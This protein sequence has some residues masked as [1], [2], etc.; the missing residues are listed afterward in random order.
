MPKDKGNVSAGKYD[1][2]I[3]FQNP[4]GTDDGQGGQTGSW[5]DAY[6]CWAA[7][8]DFPFGRGAGRAFFAQQ[9]YPTMTTMIATRFQSTYHIDATKRIKYVKNGFAHIYK[10]LGAKDPK[11]AGIEIILF[12]QEDQAKGAN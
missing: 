9:L 3:T 4:P 1:R 7:I 12:C 8:V 10:I 5:T 2:R 6:P 11:E